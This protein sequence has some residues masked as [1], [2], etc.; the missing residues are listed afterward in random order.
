M[1]RTTRRRGK[2]RLTSG[3]IVDDRDEIEFKILGWLELFDH[4]E[5]G[6][7]KFLKLDE[8][9][10]RLPRRPHRS[11]QTLSPYTEAI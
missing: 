11:Q 8:Y 9:V 6:W 10:P 1:L 7:V 2:P 5:E 3:S 4:G